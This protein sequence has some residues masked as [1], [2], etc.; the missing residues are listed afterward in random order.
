MQTLL[1]NL[2]TV[3]W[4][5]FAVKIFFASCLGGENE[6]REKKSYVYAHYIVELLGGKII[7]TRKFKKGELFLPRKFPDLWYS[8]KHMHALNTQLPLLHMVY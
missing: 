4:E 6:T 8:S 1:W 5:I 3:D 7:L 2:S